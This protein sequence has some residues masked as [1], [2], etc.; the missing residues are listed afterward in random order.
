MLG[1]GQT[2]SETIEL[3]LL[4][5]VSDLQIL[6]RFDTGTYMNVFE[7]RLYGQTY[8]DNAFSLAFLLAGACS[9]CSGST[10]C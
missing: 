5:D 10:A 2:A 4:D 1:P 9:S 3:K 7:V 6:V 8:T